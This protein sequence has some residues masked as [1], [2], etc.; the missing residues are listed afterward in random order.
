MIQFLFCCFKIKDKY[1]KDEVTVYAAQA[2][3]FIIL[4]IFPFLMLLMTLVQVIPGITK[5]DFLNVM[6]SL[7]PDLL[8]SLTVSIVDD[9]YTKSPA[10]ILSVTAIVALWSAGK[11]MMGI[12]RGMNRIYESPYKRGYVMRRLI[13]SVYTIVFMVV[14]L[15][16]LGLLVFGTSLQRFIIRTFPLFATI[17]SHLISFRS[18]LSLVLLLAVFTLLYT[19]LPKKK[20]NPW[21]QIPGAAFAA[22]GWMIFS[23]GF[24]IYFEHFSRFSYMYGSLTAII[25]LMLWLYFCI[26]I[27]FIGAEINYFLESVMN[28]GVDR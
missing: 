6:V 14:C 10:T 28:S 22:L 3:F 2:S 20:Q 27:V 4:A 17:T 25:L 15:L 18:L 13:C 11:G 7:M 1:V 12:E 26:C 9:L 21:K 16:S 5:S 19:I 23:Y 24:S 8:D